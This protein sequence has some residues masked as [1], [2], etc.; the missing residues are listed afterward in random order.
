MTNQNNVYLVT[1]GHNQ[2]FNAIFSD[3]D[4]AR[5]SIIYSYHAVKDLKI[6]ESIGYRLE[7]SGTDWQGL[8]FNH[9][10]NIKLVEPLTG[11]HHL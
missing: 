3:Y 11:I 9:A 8:F 10:F 4:S 7:L 1:C 2:S 5:Q 6:T